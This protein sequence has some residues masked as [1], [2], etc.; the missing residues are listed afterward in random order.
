M[1]IIHTIFIKIT[2]N[3]LICYLPILKAYKNYSN[4]ALIPYVAFVKTVT[5]P[6]SFIKI[7]HRGAVR[8]RKVDNRHQ[9]GLIYDLKNTKVGNWYALDDYLDNVN[10]Y[11]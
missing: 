9:L 4:V 10:G 6:N 8:F 2:I 7:K 5:T 1:I 11:Y 3:Y